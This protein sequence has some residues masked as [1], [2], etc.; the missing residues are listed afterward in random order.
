M[1]A[2]LWI[3]TGLSFLSWIVSW[4]L[5]V[6]LRRVPSGTG[7]SESVARISVIIPARNEEANIEVLLKSLRGSRFHEVIVVDDQS[8]DRT[9]VVAGELGA[10]V[11]SGEAPPV[12][13]L[14]K[15]WA[16]HQGAGV[17]TGDW[18]LFVDAD[19]KFSGGGFERLMGL[20]EGDPQ[21]HSVCPYH[22]VRAPYE[23][24]SAFFNITMILGV[25]AFTA[26]GVAARDIGLFGQVMLVSR[27]Q[28]DLVGGHSRVRGDVLEN[29]KLSR[30]FAAAGVER[31]CW[32]GKNTISMRM[33]PGGI[34]DLIAGWSK[35]TVSG[36]ANTPKSVLLGV[37]L[38]M[39]GLFMSAVP[40]CFLLV[41]P[42]T[43][44]VAMASLYVLW[45]LQCG[46]LFRA[47]GR[48]SILAASAFP[49]G[50]TFYQLVFFQAV[51][52]KK[53]GGTVQWKG[54]DV[55]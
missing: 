55:A 19:T 2:A 15:P 41:A 18:L 43:L 28:Y 8:E 38:W 46:Y 40:V 33:F 44:A 26:R 5:F 20:T 17:A 42:P 10:H 4:G 54:R 36:A 25:N 7:A 35:G 52:R 37:S 14:G 29:F 3:V 45:V 6:R 16:C 23:Q 50:L 9:K 51:L 22:E 13:W 12:G 1:E 24:L 31:R 39:S 34:R 48:Y 47:S 27:E 30:C 11:L 32:L 53:K 21:V 49:L